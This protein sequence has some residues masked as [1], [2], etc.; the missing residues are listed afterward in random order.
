MASSSG[1]PSSS[2]V[3]ASQ[4][5]VEEI[6]PRR[7]VGIPTFDLESYG[8]AY[9]GHTKILRLIFIAEHCPEIEKEAYKLAI[10]EIKKTIN[11]VLYKELTSKVGDRLGPE[12]KLDQPWVDIIDKKPNK[13]K[14]S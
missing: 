8:S 5:A 14:K 13:R 9:I 7:S 1:A 2:L 11:T 6:K 3:T 4:M 10:D 12:Y